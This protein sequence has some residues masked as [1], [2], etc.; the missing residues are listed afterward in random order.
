MIDVVALAAAEN[1][2]ENTANWLTDQMVWIALVVIIAVLAFTLIKR[3]FVGAIIS[4]IAGSVVVY[5]IANPNVIKTLGETIMNK[6][7]GG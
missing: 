2:G 3:N 5:F 4:A 7:I 6:I 1:F